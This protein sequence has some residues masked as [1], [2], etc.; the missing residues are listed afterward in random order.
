MMRL[1]FG[2]ESNASSEPLWAEIQFPAWALDGG[3]VL[4]VLYMLVLL[5]D[6]WMETRNC[7]ALRTTAVASDMAVIVASNAGVLALIFS[8]TP[9]TTQ[10]GLQYWFLAGVLHGVAQLPKK[11]LA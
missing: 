9:F 8:F 3:I 4:L 5:Q 1:Y 6:T 2:D 7:I 11:E 10:I